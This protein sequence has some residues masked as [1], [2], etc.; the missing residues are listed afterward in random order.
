MF[1]EDIGYIVRSSMLDTIFIVD[2]IVN[3]GDL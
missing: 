1:C 2:T 3:T